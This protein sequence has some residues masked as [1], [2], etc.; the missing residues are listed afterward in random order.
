M[1]PFTGERFIPTESGEI[2]VEHYHR[3]ALAR[4]LAHGKAVLDL[5]CGEGYG[6]ALLSTV[7]REVVGVDLAPDAVAHAKITYGHLSN[8]RFE[9][10]C[11]TQTR[12]LDASFDVVVSF[13]TIEHLAEQAEMLAEI[14]RLLKPDGVLIMSSPNRPV[15][16]DGRDH[17]NEFHV[18]ELDFAE[19]DSLLQPHF[20]EVA[21]YGQR[22]VMGTVV[23]PLA[24]NLLA[25]AAFTDD[26]MAVQERTFNMQAPAYFLAVCGPT[27][28]ELPP[29]YASIYMPESLDLVDHYVDFGRWAQKQNNEIEIRD[30]NVRHYKKEAEAYE[31]KA[32]TLRQAVASQQ[33]EIKALAQQREQLQVEIVRA[34]A[35]LELLKDLHLDPD[36]PGI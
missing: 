9:C 36:S 29:L 14:R 25:Y 30:K 22:L 16:S 23:Q 17:H 27:G 10:S 32:F 21:Y 20:G 19:F 6:S 2:R 3:Y 34:Q 13:E 8:L 12:L 1:L 18:K 28:M 33:D 26:G 5:A 7:A 35:Q 31:Q 24:H 15:Y 11:A 4:T